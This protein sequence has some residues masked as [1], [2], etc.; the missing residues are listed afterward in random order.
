MPLQHYAA[1][2]RTLAWRVQSGSSITRCGLDM[3]D[4]YLFALT[5]QP[6]HLRSQRHYK[7]TQGHVCDMLL[8]DY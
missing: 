8:T 5:Q 6:I 1:N 7:R 3:C 2:T 4:S